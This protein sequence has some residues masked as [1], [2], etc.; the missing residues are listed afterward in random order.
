MF[1]N[2][3]KSSML[4][5]TVSKT[6]SLRPISYFSSDLL[7]AAQHLQHEHKAMSF[8]TCRSN[9]SRDL[10]GSGR[11]FQVR[12]NPGS[13][14]GFLSCKRLMIRIVTIRSTNGIPTVARTYHPGMDRANTINGAMKNMMRMY[15]AA[16]HLYFEVTRPR[17]R[18]NLMGT[19]RIK[20]IGYQIRI[21]VKLKNRW[22]KA[23][24]NA[25]TI[26]SPEVA[27]AASRAVDVVPMLAPSIMGN[28]L[29][30]VT[31]PIPT[32]GVRADATTELLC[33]KIVTTAPTRIAR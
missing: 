7:I 21:P 22:H 27:K 15:I 24:W 11:N 26:L 6:E 29:S 12:R 16:N 17:N 2:F 25:D 23:I 14:S 31:N 4:S 10:R 28:T 18:A 19:L 33:T 3:L 9:G 32:N 13:H 30:T 8:V 1:A 5:S 20:G